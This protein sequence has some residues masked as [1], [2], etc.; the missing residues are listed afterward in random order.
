MET[1]PEILVTATRLKESLGTIDINTSAKPA[2]IVKIDEEVWGPLAHGEIESM[3]INI[4]GSFS[5]TFSYTQIGEASDIGTIATNSKLAK[6][7]AIQPKGAHHTVEVFGGYVDDP[8]NVSFNQLTSLITGVIDRVMMDVT[9]DELIIRGRDRSAILQETSTYAQFR[10]QLLSDI[11]RQ[12]A[13]DNDFDTDII[14]SGTRFGTVYDYEHIGVE[15]VPTQG[16]NNWEL[17]S[18]FAEY[19]DYVVFV[20][21]NTIH[22]RPIEEAN[23]TLRFE[24]GTNVNGLELERNYS[25]AAARI[26]VEVV[27]TQ[28]KTKEGVIATAGQKR[29]VGVGH[30]DVAIKRLVISNISQEAAGYLAES[31]ALALAQFEYLVTVHTTGHPK[32]NLFNNFVLV[33]TDTAHDRVYRIVRIGWT[34]GPEAGWQV[35][36]TGVSLPE[37]SQLHTHRQRAQSALTSVQ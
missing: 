4:N 29:A 18:R 33:G 23:E 32:Q 26:G 8:D 24:L 21:G 36:L 15:T 3:G 12:I 22:Y 1:L 35:E 9:E 7:L 28:M 16:Y 6:L 30:G 31:F 34:F 11:I 14:E 17:L 5:L 19:D 27:S 37:G 2:F 25:V 13:D 20:Q 10:N